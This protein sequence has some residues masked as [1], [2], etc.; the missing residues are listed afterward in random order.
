MS[1]LNE[2]LEKRRGTGSYLISSRVVQVG[3]WRQLLR[4]KCCW[5]VIYTS[6][7]YS[8]MIDGLFCFVAVRNY[9]VCFK[10]LFKKVLMDFSVFGSIQMSALKVGNFNVCFC[11]KVKFQPTRTLPLLVS[12]PWCLFFM[13]RI[14]SKWTSWAVWPD[15]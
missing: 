11:M 8:N 4:M 3:F 15:V 10:C 7:K 5:V 1:C 6:D 12:A 13:P 2:P 9:F 14:W